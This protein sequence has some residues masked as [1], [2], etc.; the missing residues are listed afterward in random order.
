VSPPENVNSMLTFTR[1][2]DCTEGRRG[3]RAYLAARL[4][5]E[6]AAIV[7]SVPVGWDLYRITG[8]P[9]ALGIVGL[10]QFAPIVLLSLPV[11]EL[12]DRKGPRGLFAL[13]LAIQ[14]VCSLLLV[15]GFST[16]APALWA[17]YAIMG[18]FG[19]GRTLSD[20]AGHAL[21]PMIISPERLP[22]AIAWD[23]SYSQA[24]VIVGPALGGLAYS[25]S[26]GLAY[27][28]CCACFCAA[29]LAT[30]VPTVRPPVTVSARAPTL[31]MRVKRVIDG[32]RFIKSAP[33]LL[34]AISL[35]LAAVLLG[36]ATTLLPVF[37][38][39][40]LHVGTRGLGLLRSAPAVGACLVALWQT[41]HPSGRHIGPKLFASVVGFG[42]ATTVFGLS[43]W[44]PLSLAALLCLGASDMVSVNIRASLVQWA[45]PDEMRG[46]V[47]AV[48]ML[49][50]GASSELG[51]FESGLA[52][53][54]L[55]T[56]PAVVLGGIGT[57]AVAVIW[58]RLFPALMGSFG[59]A[60]RPA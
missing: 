3:L 30:A 38:H 56:V 41:R 40:V 46:R 23:G 1:Q 57:V 26:P 58:I 43:R 18:F 33:L 35:D 20:T 34:G 7:L 19:L 42:L 9:L 50:I 21:L 29:V 5:S 16:S 60:P 28:L 27:G 11:G 4:L 25:V 54:L 22:A 17:V 13:G 47:S 44:M 52:A 14:G 32:L 24:A 8:T 39:D 53:A 59:A 37:A 31:G 6:T 12:C 55:G 49:F 10:A 36:G 2:V 51:A 15:V 45:T 48:N